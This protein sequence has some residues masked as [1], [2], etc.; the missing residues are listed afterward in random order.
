MNS[1]HNGL[2][3]QCILVYLDDILVYLCNEAEYE[4]YLHTMFQQLQS[5]K[6]CAKHTKC[7]FGVREIEY[8]GHLV[9]ARQVCT[10]PSKVSTIADWPQPMSVKHV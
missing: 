5:C 1:M 6:L 7:E 4:R 2:F 10:D 8:L 9:A 3:D